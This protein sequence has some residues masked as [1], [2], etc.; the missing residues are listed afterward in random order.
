MIQFSL[1]GIPVRVEP[2][3]WLTLALIGGGLSAR[4]SESLLVVALFV[5]A[6]FVSVLIHEMGHALIC[7][8]YTS[9]SPR[10]RG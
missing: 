7:L 10:D 1:F 5:L 9:P 3:F 4:D 6:G 2:I 8:L